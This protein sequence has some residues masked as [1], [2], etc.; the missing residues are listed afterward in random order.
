MTHVVTGLYTYPVKSLS[1]QR[2]EDVTVSSGGT[3]PYDRAYALKR[4]P[5]PFD[6]ANPEYKVKTFFH[7]LMKDERLAGIKSDFDPENGTLDLEDS[8]GYSASGKVGEPEGRASLEQLLKRYLC[9]DVE[10][11]NAPDFS[12]SDVPMK[13]VSIINLASVRA[14]GAAVGADL[15]PLRFRGNIQID[16][17]EPWSEFDLTGKRFTIGGATFETVK[18][19]TRCAATNVNPKTAARDHNLVKALQKTFGHPDMGIY[20]KVVKGGPLRVGDRVGAA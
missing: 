11:L 17:G 6:A 12:F 19:I 15:D 13:V 1:G 3:F 5:W 9:Q 14:L 20:A 16:G 2:L 4:G 7:V 18:R 10:I 8:T